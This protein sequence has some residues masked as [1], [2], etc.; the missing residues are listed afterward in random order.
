MAT[1]DDDARQTRFRSLKLAALVR[2]HHGRD[3]DATPGAFPVGA[4]SMVGDAA[5]VL[6]EDHPERGL[7]PALAWAVRHG[8]TS[9]HVLADHDTGTLARRA[10]AFG[11]AI[12]VWHV[13]ER[14]LLPAVAEPLAPP[15]AASPD[16]LELRGAI[17]AGGATPV[18]EH[19]VVLG[20]VRG[21]EVCRVVGD[22]ATG[23]VRL[24]VGVGAH[25]REAFAMIHGEVP[26]ASALRGVVDA[27]TAHRQPDAPDHPLGRLLPERLLR[28][29]LVEQPE[30]IGLGSLAATEPPLP[31]P[32][33]KD[34][35][36]ATA[37][38][39]TPA[40]DPV[41]VVCSVGVDLDLV[42]YATDA[43]LAVQRAGG[44]EPG[45]GDGSGP[46]TWLVVPARDHVAITTDLANL[47]NEPM[48]I[49]AV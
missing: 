13:A 44:G 14:T 27:V 30:R 36:P 10:E 49:V 12:E 19:G 28:W 20:D 38:G 33:V 22:G 5:W 39:L 46:G 45:V 8:A 29:D 32:N 9:L 2:E 34:R 42:P 17:A 31:R 24:E 25:D 48:R 16:H 11:F 41:V 7:G 3:L 21:L 47:L 40:G 43:R 26:A 1:P 23:A 37:R 15:S 35:L 4:A 6:V 18:V